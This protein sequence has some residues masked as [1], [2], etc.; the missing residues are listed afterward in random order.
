MS[1]AGLFQWSPLKSACLGCCWLL[2]ALLFVLGV[3]NL[4]W[5]AVLTLIVLLEKTL[6]LGQFFSRMAGLAMIAWG[7]WLIGS[8]NL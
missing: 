7:V 2:M 5:I 1:L 3:M 4:L 8:A 6:P